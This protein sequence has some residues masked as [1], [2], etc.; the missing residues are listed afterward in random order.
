MEYQINLWVVIS[1][2]NKKVHIFQ[3]NFVLG[4][5]AS[6]RCSERSIQLPKKDEELEGNENVK[7]DNYL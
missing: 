4:L 6:T 7:S 2:K 1:L 3:N 5:M